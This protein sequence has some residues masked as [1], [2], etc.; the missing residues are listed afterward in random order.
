MAHYSLSLH[1]IIP[2]PPGSHSTGPFSS[3]G[4]ATTRDGHPQGR[5]PIMALLRHYANTDSHTSEVLAYR[6]GKGFLYQE[7]KFM[8]PVYGRDQ[9]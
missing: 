6:E 7:A 3:H 1:D 9:D 8:P 4:P 2:E 5:E